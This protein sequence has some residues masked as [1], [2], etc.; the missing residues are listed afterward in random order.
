MESSNDLF[1]LTILYY[2]SRK[3]S[4]TTGVVD[5]SDQ[6]KEEC[7]DRLSPL[8]SGSLRWSEL[9]IDLEKYCDNEVECG[10]PSPTQHSSTNVSTI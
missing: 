4:I 5:R 8:A 1:N 2:R 7:A 10:G 9:N 3:T 6:L